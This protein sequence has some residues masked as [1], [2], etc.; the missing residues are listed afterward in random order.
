MSST[1]VRTAT[2]SRYNLNLLMF[3]EIPV[4]LAAETR[5]HRGMHHPTVVDLNVFDKAIFE[6]STAWKHLIIITIWDTHRDMQVGEVVD[7]VTTMVY[8]AL[9]MEPLGHVRDP[10]QRRDPATHRNITSQHVRGLAGDPLCHTVK[11]TR[12]KLGVNHWDIKL[13]LEFGVVLDGLFLQRILVP[14]EVEILNRPA[15]AER[16]FIAI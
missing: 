12:S 7:R 13:L 5:T 6:G 16:I 1:S 14:E 8:L 3:Y 10:H 11:P 4:Y 2:N 15:N 9:H